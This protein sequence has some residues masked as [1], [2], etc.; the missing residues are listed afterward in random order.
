[1]SQV[2]EEL[3]EAIRVLPGVGAK[4]AQRYALSLVLENRDKAVDLARVIKSATENLR[5]CS[6]CGNL[7]EADICNICADDS[8][9]N[10]LICVV[11]N[12]RE[13][14]SIEGNASFKGLYHVL[15]GVISP[16]KG[17]GPDQLNI[18]SL[19]KKAAELSD[20]SEII[21]ALGSSIESQATMTYLFEKLGRFNL[22]ITILSQG[23]PVG[24]SLE[25]LDQLTL[26][27]AFR[28]RRKL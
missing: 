9:D 2:L 18:A 5:P 22:E 7:S 12:V 8:R 15:G 27:A 24:T 3:M 28:Q 23:V 4:T 25:Y 13:L 6:L 1:M 21:L 10:Q 11:E 26:E 14:L 17:V 20:G 19:L 16:I